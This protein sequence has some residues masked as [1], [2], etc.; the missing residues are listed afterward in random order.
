MSDSL[1][2]PIQS[3]ENDVQIDVCPQ[4]YYPGIETAQSIMFPDGTLLKMKYDG[5]LPYVPIRCSTNDKIHNCCQL[6]LNSRDL[7][8]PFTFN[9]NFSMIQH[10]FIPDY[11]ALFA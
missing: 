8:G 10:Y 7:W 2:N 3:E 1:V 4:R 5:V 11:E 6:Q 9:G